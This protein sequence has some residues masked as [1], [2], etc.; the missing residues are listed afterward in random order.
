MSFSFFNS[1]GTIACAITSWLAANPAVI[2]PLGPSAAAWAIESDACWSGIASFMAACSAD[3]LRSRGT[4][5]GSKQPRRVLH[6]STDSQSSISCR[7]SSVAGI[8]MC[9][10]YCRVFCCTIHS[11]GVIVPWAITSAT[12]G[13]W[14]AYS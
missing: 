14:T 3:F 1:A 4:A 12:L 6:D 5:R 8:F 11:A 2:A 10:L 9:L 7:G 13:R